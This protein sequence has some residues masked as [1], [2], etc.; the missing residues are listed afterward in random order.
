MAREFASEGFVSLFLYTR[1]A[2]PG[3]N[4]PAHRSME[5]KLAH[6]SAFKE[7]FQIER[8]ILVDDSFRREERI[9]MNSTHIW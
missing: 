1:E 5:Q 3:E 8:P 9:E 2:H 7:R 6:A 4:F